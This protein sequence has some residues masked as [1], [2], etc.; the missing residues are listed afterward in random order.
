METNYDK[1]GNK[2]EYIEYKQGKIEKW[3]IYSYN[4]KN[5][6]IEKIWHNCFGWDKS[7]FKAYSEKFSYNDNG[8]L[9][10]QNKTTVETDA[11]GSK[12]ETSFYLNGKI[13]GK[14]KFNPHG[15]CI[16]ELEYKSEEVVRKT[17]FDDN[18]NIHGIHNYDTKGQP[19][20]YSLFEYDNKGNRTRIKKVSRT[21]TVS[22][23]RKLTYDE[24]DNLIEDCDIPKDAYK[25]HNEHHMNIVG[26]LEEDPFE[27]YKHIYRHDSSQ[28]LIE[29]YMYLA[30]RLIMVYEYEYKFY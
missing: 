9:I 18:G 15:V 27:G 13:M 2:I 4:A 29:H 30:E 10:T 14:R 25:I 7:K 5:E 24:N 6:L 1:H 11:D 28:L 26:P 21:G 12:I 3:E 23:D 17:L 20:N 16:E 22:Q 8:L 19:L